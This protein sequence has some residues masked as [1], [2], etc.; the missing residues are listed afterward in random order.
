MWFKMAAWCNYFPTM[1]LTF[2][3]YISPHILLNCVFFFFI[4]FN[5]FSMSILLWVIDFFW[6]WISIWMLSHPIVMLSVSVSAEIQLYIAEGRKLTIISSIVSNIYGINALIFIVIC[7]NCYSLWSLSR[8]K[9]WYCELCCCLTFSCDTLYISVFLHMNFSIHCVGL[10]VVPDRVI[11]AIF[12]FSCRAEFSGW[13][14]GQGMSMKNCLSSKIWKAWCISL[15]YGKQRCICNILSW[16]H[17]KSE[18]QVCEE[19]FRWRGSIVYWFSEENYHSSEVGGMKLNG[20]LAPDNWCLYAG[21][22]YEGS[23]AV[24]GS[25]LNAGGHAF[26]S[27]LFRL[28]FQWLLPDDASSPLAQLTNHLQICSHI[29]CRAWLTCSLFLKFPHTQLITKSIQQVHLR[30]FHSTDSIKKFST[31]QIF[32][33]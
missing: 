6:R 20:K 11:S 13:G 28:P 27:A 5:L 7:I 16:H 31:S 21:I 10:F 19:G 12:C 26:N 18:I 3:M 29:E 25:L 2:P 30:Q 8:F 23:C 33:L 9:P 15:M 32:M 14:Q 1:F 24:D 22:I 17:S 4:L